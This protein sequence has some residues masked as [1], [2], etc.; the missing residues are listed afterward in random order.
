MRVA[1]DRGRAPVTV[2]VVEEPDP[3]L[4]D[5]QHAVPAPELTDVELS[6][7]AFE[8]K[9]W[10]YAGAKESAV[11]EA[12]GMSMTRY[13]QVLNILLDKPA[14]LAADPLTVSRL[15]R[16]RASRRDQRTGRAAADGT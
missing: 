5:G 3:C 12:F 15:R 11:L 13:Y 4:D 6:V 1:T 10:K 7:L 8:R 16:L 9:R 14:A 2:T